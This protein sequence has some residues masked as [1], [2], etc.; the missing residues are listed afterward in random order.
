M[1]RRFFHA[2]AAPRAGALLGAGLLGLTAAVH[3]Q[4]PADSVRV[5]PLLDVV[6]PR[7]TG[8]ALAGTRTVTITPATA[9]R[10]GAVTLADALE[11]RGG[12]FLRR[13]GPG[14]LAS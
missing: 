14:G 9:A 3:A 10:V 12:A 5:L 13:Y 11:R 1:R 2:P 7:G 6:A 8:A 4:P